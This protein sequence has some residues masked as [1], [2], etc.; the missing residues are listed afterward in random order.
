MALY[1]RDFLHEKHS[2]QSGLA[3][4]LAELVTRFHQFASLFEVH[5]FWQFAQPFLVAIHSLLEIASP[6]QP[7]QSI[8]S[9]IEVKEC[10][11]LEESLEFLGEQVVAEVCV[12]LLPSKTVIHRVGWRG[13]V[14]RCQPSTPRIEHRCLGRQS[15]RDCPAFLAAAAAEAFLFHP[16]QRR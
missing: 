6:I 12:A 2:Q 11:S 8:L 1:L 13:G 5:T 14:E 4:A 9:V 15:I 7:Y 10:D 3:S 16:S